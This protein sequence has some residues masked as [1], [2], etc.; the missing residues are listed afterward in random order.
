[1]PLL[2]QSLL[3]TERLRLSVIAEFWEIPVTS[4]RRREMAL[5]LEEAMPDPEAVA[6]ALGKLTR[7]QEEALQALATAGGILPQRVFSREWGEIR[8]MGPGR[9]DRERPWED[10][11]SPAEA[12]WYSGFLFKTFAEGPDGAYEAVAIPAEILE[13]LPSPEA[14]RSELSLEPAS[15]PGVVQAAGPALLEDACT[16]LSYVHNHRP[17]RGPDGAWSARDTGRL[18]SR[19]LDQDEDRFGFIRHLAATVGW[20]VGEEAKRT[21]LIPES[22]TEWLR[23]PS[24][25]QRKDLSVGWRDDPAWNDLFHVP[26][27][28]PED[29]GAWKNDPVLAREAILSHLAVCTPS[30]WYSI[31]AF[32]AGIQEVDPDFQRP[33]GDYETWYIKDR[34][35]G[36]YLSG[37]ESWDA[38]E[39][40][41]IRYVLT[42][43]LFW[44]GLVDLGAER[45]DRSSRV[46]RLTD[47]GGALLD[48]KDK[49]PAPEPSAL[50]L[51]AGFQLVVPWGRR[52]ERFQ[53]GRVAEWLES[54]EHYRYRF[55]AASLQ[56]ARDQRIGVSRVLAF[57]EDHLEAPLP[58]SFGEA[59]N[60]WEERGTE[61]SLHRAVL[62]RMANEELMDRALSSPRVA[63]LVEERISS[64]A[65]VVRRHDWP[66]MI[67]AL[68]RL[69][70]LP[71]LPDSVE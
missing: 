52:Y 66:A 61:A 42:G 9:M 62:L 23:S 33:T 28:Q 14:P 11:V 15:E 54:G 64:T 36:A 32:I 18:L 5:E 50:R 46:F 71:G 20:I 39:G 44:L 35:T 27:L 1:M 65:A 25:E 4:H 8:A 53:V 22:V 68:G 16:F 57:L 58:S 51:R 2:R 59:L 41:L 56:R 29:T 69:G 24:F 26:T 70:L 12:L 21:T 13:L 10:P 3:E 63:R 34:V 37:F 19:M 55:T 45:R 49:P 38:V 43:P 31:E 7:D 60:R 67:E 30:T 40:R 6:K 47:A 17:S 48:L